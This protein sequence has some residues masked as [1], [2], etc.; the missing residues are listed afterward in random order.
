KNDN[1]VS[2]KYVHSTRFYGKNHGVR[3]G[4]VRILDSSNKL[5]N[6][7]WLDEENGENFTKQEIAAEPGYSQ[8]RRLVNIPLT[9]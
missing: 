5:I 7:E 3:E 6:Q 9:L 2:F 8:V 1:I 4:E